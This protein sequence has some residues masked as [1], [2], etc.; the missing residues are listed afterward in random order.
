MKKI[1]TFIVVITVLTAIS[2]C[3]YAVYTIGMRGEK[4]AE[5]PVKEETA[6]ISQPVYT[7]PAPGSYDS[8]DEAAVVL[9]VDAEE[10]L[11]TLHNMDVNRNYTLDYS[12]A[13]RIED[14]HGSALS[15]A[16]VKAGDVVEVTFLKNRKRL[17]TLALCSNEAWSVKSTKEFAIN[18]N[19]KL[20]LL[21]KESYLINDDTLIFSEGS[22][23]DWMDI[24]NVDLLTVNGVGQKVYSIV[25]ERGHG[26]LRLKND[27]YFV[28]GWIEVGDSVICPIKKDMLL[29]VPE[30]K[31][32]VLVSNNGN[33]GVK[34]IQV[35]R[36]KE[37][38]LDIGDIEI[39]ETKVG[40]VL[41]SVTP[42]S[43]K[44]YVDGAAVD[45][46]GPIELEYGIHQVIAGADGYETMTRY[47]KVGES[48]ASLDIQL[49]KKSAATVSSNENGSATDVNININTDP[50][51]QT[52]DNG[53]GNVVTTTPEGQYRVYVTGPEG[54]ELYVDGT[55]IGL[56]PTNF[57]KSAGTHVIVLRKP[58]FVTRSYT[59]QIDSE[60]KDISYSFA[61]L[62]AETGDKSSVS[63]NSS[64]S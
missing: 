31:H 19:A 46:A 14:R 51:T 56:T 62:E 28:G 35:E 9:S 22:Q 25:I 41:F 21:G 63:Q 27:Q 23:A 40:R 17:N 50:N 18:R 6:G 37:L 60:Q 4:P 64:G 42:A 59:V 52:T 5:T 57:A 47:I 12:Q 3:G 34:Q 26:Y 32:E 33:S 49:E 1:G 24:N 45:I 7:A 58:G 16:Q 15:M 38:E 39:T 61:E 8:L 11:I 29:T 53:Q 30:G 2:L 54:A 10:K 36:G 48:L 13:T 55:Y 43:T 20:M 44:V